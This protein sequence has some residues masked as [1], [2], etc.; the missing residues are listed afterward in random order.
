ML[1]EEMRIISSLDV[2]H[3]LIERSE[4]MTFAKH[5]TGSSHVLV[6]NSTN[7]NLKSNAVL[8]IHDLSAT[9]P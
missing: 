3:K 6:Y 2:F 5:T 7:S 9:H 8:V 4:P 1:R